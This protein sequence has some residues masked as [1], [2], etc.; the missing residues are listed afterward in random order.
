LRR[1]W[2][3]LK[4]FST[5]HRVHYAPSLISPEWE[6][7]MKGIRQSLLINEMGQSNKGNSKSQKNQLTRYYSS[8]TRAFIIGLNALMDKWI[9]KDE[10]K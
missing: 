2:D 8:F 3:L 4:Y 10:E 6:W 1:T 9:D 5:D 7:R